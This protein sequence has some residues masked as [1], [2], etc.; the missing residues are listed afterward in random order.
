MGVLLK[1]IGWYIDGIRLRLY[2][3]VDYINYAID[4]IMGKGKKVMG[5]GTNIK[6]GEAEVEDT[7]GTYILETT[8][9][10]ILV[11]EEIPSNFVGSMAEI[12][13]M[14]RNRT[15]ATGVIQSYLLA[16]YDIHGWIEDVLYC[17]G[18]MG[19]ELEKAYIW[20]CE[21]IVSQNTIH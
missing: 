19:D 11:P 15:Y 14:G 16:G 4:Y 2:Y 3:I 17:N 6:N 13:A 18:L 20:W 7:N 5:K 9:G 12:S 1:G 10:N 8:Y 21:Y